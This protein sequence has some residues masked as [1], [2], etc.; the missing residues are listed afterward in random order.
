MSPRHLAQF[1]LLLG[2][3]RVRKASADP[4]CVQL[5]L[6]K[7]EHGTRRRPAV[8]SRA[9][10]ICFKRTQMAD[11]VLQSPTQFLP[12]LCRLQQRRIGMTPVALSGSAV[13]PSI[14]FPLVLIGVLITWCM[15]VL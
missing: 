4:F 5:D 2:R 13:R 9:R 6:F 14:P 12:C 1:E 8:I 10:P 15:N 11:I 3:R 7:V